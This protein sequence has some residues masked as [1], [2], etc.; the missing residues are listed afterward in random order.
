MA[1]IFAS[2]LVTGC[3]S[4][5]S[6]DNKEGSL[7]GKTSETIGTL[8]ILK[9]MG[10]ITLKGFSGP[11]KVAYDMDYGDGKITENTIYYKN[12]TKLRIDSKSEEYETQSYLIGQTAIMCTK[13]DGKT[14]CL[15]A[16]SEETM[17]PAKVEI[18][19]SYDEELTES[20]EDINFKAYRDGTITVSGHNANCYNIEYT[21][22]SQRYC[23]SKEGV[24]LYTKMIDEEGVTEFSAKSY[25]TTVSEADFEI[26]KDAEIIDMNQELETL[27]EE[28]V[29]EIQ[30]IE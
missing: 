11:Y 16:T 24:M 12:E 27:Q 22:A 7:I 23:F 20:P 5:Q 8:S 17:N 29:R 13:K 26:P 3:S 28:Y 18:N 30:Y 21:N 10:E 1:M 4:G 25:S 19:T 15:K 6:S 2:L 14:T 9:E